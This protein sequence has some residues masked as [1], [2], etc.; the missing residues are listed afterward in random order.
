MSDC[1]LNESRCG[2]E[3][4]ILTPRS[5]VLFEKL[6]G[7]QLVKKFPALYGIR[8]FIAA[9]TSNG[10]LALSCV[11]SIQSIPPHPYLLSYFLTYLHTSLLTYLLTT[12][13]LT[14]LLTSLL[15]YFLTYLLTYYL[16][17]YLLTYYL[18]TYLLHGTESFL[19]CKP[20]LS[21]GRNSLYFMKPEN[22]LPRS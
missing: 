2:K 21:Q 14:S 9:F 3:Y 18:L 12:Y 7:S 6:N 20:V 10:H 17:T 15:T 11:S 5:R 4:C 1:E 19:R 22:L 16:L 8:R 13:L